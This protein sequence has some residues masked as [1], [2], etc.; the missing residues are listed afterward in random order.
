[1]AHSHPS[2]LL[3]LLS[4]TKF[5]FAI[6][7]L[8][9]ILC[10]IISLFFPLNYSATSGV[11]VIPR[12]GFG[13]DPYT[14][15]KSAE[16]LGENLARAVE[17]SEFRDKV[18]GSEPAIDISSW[19]AT[20]RSRR[21]FWNRI[22]DTNVLPGTGLLEVTAYSPDPRQAEILSR[23]VVKT[24]TQ[25]GTEYIGAQVS[26]KISDDPVASRFPVK[27]NLIVN[28]IVG[29]LFGIILASLHVLFAVKRHRPG[30]EHVY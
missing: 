30:Q 24:L 13:V 5:L 12:Q 27:P 25:S 4:R 1:M 16:R 10:V 3:L 18:L 26:F 2:Y 14:V 28:A 6:G 17:S 15:I 7:I 23:A 29:F 21:R 20:E 8:V 9:A 19:P 22:I 11:F